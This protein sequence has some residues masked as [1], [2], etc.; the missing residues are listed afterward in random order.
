MKKYLFLL[1]VFCTSLIFL[2]NAYMQELEAFWTLVFAGDNITT[3]VFSGG[4][5][6]TAGADKALNCIT[7]KGTFLWRRNTNSY[8]TPL[9]STSNG[10]VV[11]LITKGCNIEAYSS[12][13]M[14]IWTYKCQKM[15]L[16]PVYVANDGY[17]IVTF[18]DKIISL[19]RQGQLKWELD[20]P[21]SPIKEPVEVAHKNLIVLLEDDSF[22]RISMFG[23]LIET[24]SLKKKIEAISFAPF[25]YILSCNDASI[26]YYKM[27]EPSTLVWQKNEDKVVRSITYKDDAFFCIYANGDAILK[28]NE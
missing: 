20:L 19:T 27:G 14:P 18:N 5:I 6:Y 4:N 2:Q 24:L 10:G 9:I 8:P 13:G 16:F 1:Y 15:P 22:L 12:Q 7:N 3:P 25:G 26:S 21:S 11:Y 23:K 17:L 28:K